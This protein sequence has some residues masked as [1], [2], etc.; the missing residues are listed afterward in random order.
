MCGNFGLLLLLPAH[1]RATLRLL[2]KMLRITMIRGAQSAGIATYDRSGVGLR[3]RGH[4]RFATSSV[5]NIAGCHPHQWLPRSKQMAWR[6]ATNTAYRFVCERRSVESFITHNGDCDAFTIHGN[7]YLY[8]IAD[9]QLLLVRLLGHPI[10]SD[11]DSACVAGLLDMLRTKGVWLASWQALV[12]SNEELTAASQCTRAS[13]GAADAASAE[14]VLLEA[15]WQENGGAHA[16]ALRKCP[17]SR[18]A[19]AAAG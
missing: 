13:S 4:T 18:H 12:A 19:A 8:A 3:C 9:L 6:L 7:K 14:C 1:R 17:A 5:C 10:P 11:V 2:R 16:G 15:V